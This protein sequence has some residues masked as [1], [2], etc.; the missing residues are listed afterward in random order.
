AL[1]SSLSSPSFVLCIK[2]PPV[3]AAQICQRLLYVREERIR[4]L[5]SLRS[6][7][8]RNFQSAAAKLSATPAPADARGLPQRYGHTASTI[9]DRKVESRVRHRVSTRPLW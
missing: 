9:P 7:W 6:A 1:G 4:R 8:L 2:L 5:L 3:V